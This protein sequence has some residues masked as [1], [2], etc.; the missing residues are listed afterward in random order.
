MRSSLS[1]LLRVWQVSVELSHPTVVRLR[2]LCLLSL[3]LLVSKA[4]SLSDR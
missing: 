1:L 3:L 4:Q 2:Q